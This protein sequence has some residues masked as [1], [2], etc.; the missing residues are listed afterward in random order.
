MASRI[1]Y[2]SPSGCQLTPKQIIFPS[3]PGFSQLLACLLMR[4]IEVTD[5]NS[6]TLAYLVFGV[7]ENLEI[8]CRTKTTDLP[9]SIFSEVVSVSSNKNT[10]LIFFCLPNVTRLHRE[11]IQDGSGSV[12][13]WTNG[14]GGE[15]E[16]KQ[17]LNHYRYCQAT[18]RDY[19]TCQNYDNNG[20]ASV[21]SQVAL[22]IDNQ[23]YYQ[24]S[25][26]DNSEKRLV[27]EGWILS[28]SPSLHRFDVV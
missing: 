6:D 10:T 24:D 12:V 28:A 27:W 14:K 26:P 5:W 25:Q 8:G 18:D 22:C 16:R 13:I 1:L 19:R 21:W 2:Q 17:T 9:W 4:K 15:V 23:G 11:I 20:F 3:D 7:T